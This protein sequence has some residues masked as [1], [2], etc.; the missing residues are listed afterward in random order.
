MISNK[1]IKFVSPDQYG[2]VYI[3]PIYVTTVLETHGD[4]STIVMESGERWRIN[5]KAQAVVFRLQN[6]E[7]EPPV[8][9]PAFIPAKQWLKQQEANEQPAK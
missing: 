4:T 2:P 3:N 8:T 5:Q 9:D 6:P 7:R 1:F